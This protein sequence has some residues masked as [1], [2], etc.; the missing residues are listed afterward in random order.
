MDE[1]WEKIEQIFHQ[2]RELRGVARSGFLDEACRSNE[3]TRRMIE[4]ML[5]ESEDNPNFLQA[6][7]VA[8]ASNLGRHLDAMVLSAGTM[9]G[10]YAVIGTLGAGGMGQVYRA[11][12]SRLQRDVAVK[13]LPIQVANEP[14][15][16]TRFKREATVLASLNHPHIAA[17]YDVV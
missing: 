10:P 13:V 9:I 8:L 2:A 5:R 6:P 7:A 12:D 14:E 15:R 17:I 3:S 1:R 16:L 4:S 11:R